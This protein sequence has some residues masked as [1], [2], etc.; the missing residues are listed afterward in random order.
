MKAKFQQ[1]NKMNKEFLA[2]LI[3]KIAIV[4]GAFTLSSGRRTGIYIDGRVITLHPEGLKEVCSSCI[5]HIKRTGSK[6]IGGPTMGADPIVGGTL[7]YGLQRLPFDYV[8]RGFIWRRP[9]DHG[10]QKSIEGLLEVGAK[11]MIVDDVS[12]TGNSLLQVIRDVRQQYE[13]EVAC[14]HVIVDREEGAK[15]RIEAEGIEFIN[16]FTLSELG[17]K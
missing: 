16:I 4:Q 8:L 3:K 6:Y 10:T 7:V 17:G 11:V 14:V 2:D 9:K 13:A 12:T 1:G 15:E 5:H